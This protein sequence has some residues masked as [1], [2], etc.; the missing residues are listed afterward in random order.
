MAED[1]TVEGRIKY[2]GDACSMLWGFVRPYRP[3]T[4]TP[5][6]VG[7]L[8]LDVFGKFLQIRYTGREDIAR[9]IEEH[10]YDEIV[11]RLKESGF[12]QDGR[13]TILEYSGSK[14]KIIYYFLET[15]PFRVEFNENSPEART[16]AERTLRNVLEVMLTSIKNGRR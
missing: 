16:E 3:T 1:K 9:E 15:E 12:V 5:P 4:A 14:T 10:I 8:R 2:S 7:D 13:P 11:G 6:K